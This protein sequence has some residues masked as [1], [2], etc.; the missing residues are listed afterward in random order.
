MMGGAANTIISGTSW[1]MS[2]SLHK[3]VFPF[4]SRGFCTNPFARSLLHPSHLTEAPL[5]IIGHRE[6]LVE[7][8]FFYAWEE[9]RAPV[10]RTP[11]QSHS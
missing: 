7:A 5:N 11:F 9:C 8:G 10:L 2:R 6:V 1:G 3:T 4:T